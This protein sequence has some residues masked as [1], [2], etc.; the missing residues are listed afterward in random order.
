MTVK[1]L[2]DHHLEFLSLKEGCT[3]SSESTHMSKCHNVGNHM[4][5]LNYP[6]SARLGLLTCSRYT[7]VYDLRV[8][9]KCIQLYS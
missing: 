1:L 6:G 2:P 7:I 9:T 3:C 8:C 5:W 4:S